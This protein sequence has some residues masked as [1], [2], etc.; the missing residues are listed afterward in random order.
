MKVHRRS[1]SAF[2]SG[3]T[4]VELLVVIAII[5]I[6]V[7][8]LLPAI[9]AARE[10]ARRTQCANNMKQLGLAVQ[11]FE[12]VNK[13][14]PS[15]AYYFDLDKGLL[16]QGTL[17][18]RLLPYVEEQNI[19]D[20]YDFEIDPADTSGTD[21]QRVPGSSQLIG[22]IPVDTFICPSN[23]YEVPPRPGGER[24]F[25][26]ANYAGSRGPCMPPAFGGALCSL[27]ANFNAFAINTHSDCEGRGAFY[28]LPGVF[29]RIVDLVTPHQVTDGLSHTIFI[30]ETRP[31][32]SIHLAQGWAKS[33][34]GSGLVSTVP[35]INFDSCTQGIASDPCNQWN[36]W[37]TSLGFK[38]SHPGGAQ[39]VF[40]DGSV[41]FLQETMDHQAYQYLG[42]KADG[43]IIHS[44]AL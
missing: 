33:N 32:C 9:Q 17:L 43:K 5:G 6:L 19:Y 27:A 37:T 16:N 31:D 1:N 18:M 7:A 39:F 12:N 2:I 3:F 28:A 42:A 8:L 14:Y 41:R 29:N 23:V 30:G 26:V 25:A 4:L 38:S 15:G 20:L 36:N 44:N 21:F 24:G 13:T 40:G 10:A 35:P 22:A 11:L 34:N